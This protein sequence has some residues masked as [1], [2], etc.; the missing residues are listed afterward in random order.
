MN[1]PPHFNWDG[2][3]IAPGD[4]VIFTTVQGQRRSG[5]VVFS[6][7]THVTL[8]CGGRHGTPQVCDESNIK[9]VRARRVAA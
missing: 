2:R 6:F 5:R 1:R 3:V 4:R 8:N 9:E 7:P